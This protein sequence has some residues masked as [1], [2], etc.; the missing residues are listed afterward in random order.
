MK[1]FKTALLASAM[2]LAAGSANAVFV[3]DQVDFLLNAPN[4]VGTILSQT[5]TSVVDPGVEATGIFDIAGQA[6]D[7]TWTAD[8]SATQLI[9]T[10]EWI[11]ISSQIG[12]QILW[13][14]SDMDLQGG[15]VGGITGIALNSTQGPASAA[16]IASTG[17]TSTSVSVELTNFTTQVNDAQRM[18][19]FDITHDGEATEPPDIIPVPAALPLLAGGIGMLGLMARRRKK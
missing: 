3:G 7:P 16:E 2:T 9:L 1:H 4:T 11:G 12:D 17:F 8:L 5:G 10:Y 6:N 18:W 13:T 14:V 19:V 15:L